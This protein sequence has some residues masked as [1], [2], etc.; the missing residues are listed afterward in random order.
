MPTYINLINWTDQGIKSYKETIDR[1]DAA[2]EAGDKMGVKFHDIY[3]TVGQHDLVGIMEAPDD[4]TAAAF[5]LTVCAQ[6]G[7]RTTTM[8]A[9]K[10]SEMK[11]VLAKTG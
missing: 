10:K 7:I 11:D 3:W 1:Y 8:R 9:F 4:E 6:G 5:L 2:K